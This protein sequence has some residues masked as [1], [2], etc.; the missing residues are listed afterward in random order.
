MPSLRGSERSR[1]ANLQAGLDYASMGGDASV[2]PVS[3]C[4][5]EAG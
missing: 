4:V 5:T 2:K 3:L 1:A